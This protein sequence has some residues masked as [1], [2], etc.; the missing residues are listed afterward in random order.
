MVKRGGANL[1]RNEFHS[2]NLQFHIST[3]GLLSGSGTLTKPLD[4]GAIGKL[5]SSKP[6]QNVL[7]IVVFPIIVF[8]P[9][10]SLSR[11]RYE[12]KQLTSI[13]H[14]RCHKWISSTRIHAG[15]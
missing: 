10:P 15:T 4:E 7:L 1:S 8:L 3:Y 2:C 9:A 14:L 11:T 6:L 12:F 5:P 13:V